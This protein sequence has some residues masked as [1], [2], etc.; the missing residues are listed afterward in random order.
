[1]FLSIERCEQPLKCFDA[2]F[3]RSHSV[4][5]A[6]KKSRTLLL[7]GFVIPLQNF[8]RRLKASY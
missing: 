7:E 2:L 4:V 1:M 5:Q 8:L 3:E 6:L